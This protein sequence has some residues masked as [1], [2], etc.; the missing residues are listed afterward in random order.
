MR[1][2]TEFC[3]YSVHRKDHRRRY[4]AIDIADLGYEY[5]L[6]AE[7]DGEVAT[8]VVTEK[9]RKEDGGTLEGFRSD[10]KEMVRHPKDK[11]WSRKCFRS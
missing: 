5:I 9:E 6:R 11:H 8:L 2:R 1:E 10:V 3:A 7:L 4:Y